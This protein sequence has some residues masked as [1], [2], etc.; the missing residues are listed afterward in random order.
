M[1]ICVITVA[2]HGIGGMQDHTRELARG[3]AARGHDVH[4][5]T[6]AHPDG[7]AGEEV[8]GAHWH[9]VACP[10]AH[11]SLPRRHPD[12]H[13]LSY[14]LFLRLHRER[15]FDVVHS[16]SSSALGLLDH[17]VHRHLPVVAKY[18]GNA[19]ALYKASLRRVRQG[20]ASELVRE[21]KYSIW[22]LGMQTAHGSIWRLR[23]LEWM[24]PSRE[25]FHATRR[26]AFLRADIGHVVPNGIDPDVFRPRERAE[27]RAELGLGPEPLLVCVG[28]FDREKGM[29]HA[30]DAVHRLREQAPD[31]RLVLVGDGPEDEALRAQ[32]A[33]LGLAERVSFAGR[34][35]RD[36]VAA[37][38]AAADV[39]LFP[40]E[41]A[42]AAP[43]VLPQAMS[44]GVPVVASSIGGITEVI[45]P[46]TDNGVLVPPG[47]LDALVGAIG[48]LL[49]DEELHRRV[50]EAGRRRILAEYTLERM[51]DRTL[52]V[53]EI[54]TRRLRGG[55]AQ[56]ASGLLAGTSR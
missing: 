40:T 47:D 34:Q 49:A 31:L 15:P 1:R 11:P 28:R 14:E 29:H 36:V 9:Y 26:S 5:I 19:L 25:E 12:W 4:V 35:P 39:F 50:G 21:L 13:R 3:F 45:E 23:P 52:E 48:Q 17:G 32:A 30:I 38:M 16:E 46:G 22:L 7:I 44:T 55:P 56:A 24:V 53:Y 27:V 43:L 41:R 6:A 51:L 2:G 20:G 18:H 33:E 37:T 8:D 10:S 54:A 42:E